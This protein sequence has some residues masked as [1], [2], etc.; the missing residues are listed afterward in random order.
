MSE[1]T[2][3]NLPSKRCPACGETRSASA[4]NGSARTADG[5]ARNCRACTNA[6]R[7]ERDRLRKPNREPAGQPA[8]L[9][10]ALR[11][12]DIEA[13]RRLVRSGVQPRWDWI[14][15]TMR[16][17][18]LAMAEALLETGVEPNLFTMAAMG[19]VAGLTH[20][21]GRT[22][23]EARQSV[24]MQPNGLGVTPLHVA[25]AS[26][27][28]PH[29]PD[30]MAAQV[31]IAE[32]LRD[33]GADLNV[34]A[35]YRGIPDATPLFSACWSSGNLSLVRW[36]LDSGAPATDRDLAAALGHFQ[37]H[38]RAAHDIAEALLHWGVPVDGSV[39]E[40]GTPLQGFAHMGGHQTAA[41]LIAH[42][43]AVNARGPGG[44][45]AAHLA[46]E[47]NTSPATL[48]SLAESG[49]DLAALDED[50]LTPLET[51]R[52]NGKLR[53]VE[54]IEKRSCAGVG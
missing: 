30:F 50:G 34:A 8:R 5:S 2:L 52:L 39:P 16:G 9:A 31:Q 12:G 43:A 38:G 18:H 49:S 28:R 46:A 36:L 47:R 27:W 15:E 20:K 3:E 21:L 35:H 33:H 1:V 6:R 13:V 25:C 42:G 51:A 26:D 22:P 54:W 45:T 29:G 19:D 32:V 48:A 44:R 41:W 40:N 7:R 53:L 37:R 24:R 17:G 14:C 11:Q 23:E 10:K 4:F